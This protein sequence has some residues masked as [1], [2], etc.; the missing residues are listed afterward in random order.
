MDT[1]R[2]LSVGFDL[3]S[4]ELPFYC[5]FGYI[6]PEEPCNQGRGHGSQSYHGQQGCRLCAVC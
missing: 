6:A 1:K 5:C 3:E 4:F 2:L